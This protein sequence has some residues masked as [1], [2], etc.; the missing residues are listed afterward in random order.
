MSNNTQMLPVMAVMGDTHLRSS[1]YGR[2]YRGEDFFNAV[3]SAIDVAYEAGVKTIINTGDLHDV[4]TP[5]SA[6]INQLVRICQHL[7]KKHMTMWV[8]PGNHDHCEPSWLSVLQQTA[9]MF[10]G[11]L[12]MRALVD[13]SIAIDKAGLHRPITIHGISC[14]AGDAMR[15]F[16]ADPKG[17]KA[18]FL[19]WHG[20]VKEFA[21]FPN[22][23]TVSIADF[24]ACPRY[25]SILLGDVHVTDYRRFGQHGIIGYPGSTELCSA[26]EAMQ[27]YIGLVYVSPDC[28]HHE[29]QTLPIMTRKVLTLRAD[30][31]EIFQKMLVEQVIPTKAEKPMIFFK[32]NPNILDCMPRLFAAANPDSIVRGTAIAFDVSRPNVET[33]ENEEAPQA[34]TQ[35]QTRANL[36]GLL[37]QFVPPNFKDL[38]TLAMKLMDP[39]AKATSLLTDYVGAKLSKSNAQ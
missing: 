11:E 33:G 10:E 20:M 38:H 17:P 29:V 1:Q 25:Q 24:E 16:L 21:D 30:T 28:S 27:K 8:I 26:T 19:A 12:P 15:E 18:D 5:A 36:E 4:S 2:T 3:I 31:E 32:Y 22:A 9:G 13:T 7:N 39:E 34:Y 37:T 6:V 35:E 14:L 23:D